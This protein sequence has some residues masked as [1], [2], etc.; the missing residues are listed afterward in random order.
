MLLQ[1]WRAQRGENFGTLETLLLSGNR[2]I[3]GNVMA[4]SRFQTV[5]RGT[6]NA[7]LVKSGQ[8]R[9]SQAS[10]GEVRSDLVTC[11]LCYLARAARRKFYFCNPGARSAEKMLCNARLGHPFSLISGNAGTTL[12]SA[13]EILPNLNW[14]TSL[15]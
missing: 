8:V 13:K 1:S 14:V 7:F 3:A 5:L 12:G 9:S 6:P 11:F 4:P 2:S 15:L 10:S